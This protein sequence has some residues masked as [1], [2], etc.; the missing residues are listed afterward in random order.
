MSTSYQKV[1]LNQK[2]QIYHV[3]NVINLNYIEQR[4]K[5]KLIIIID[6]ISL[7]HQEY[8]IPLSVTRDH[9]KKFSKDVRNTMSSKL[10]SA[11]TDN[12]V[13][14]T[15]PAHLHKDDISKT[16]RCM[17]GRFFYTH[18]IVMRPVS[19]KIRTEIRWS[20]FLAHI[21]DNLEIICKR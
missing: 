16:K 17:L 20:M 14:T 9:L 7:S 3:L 18:H 21:V 8:R 11:F 5:E 19:M 13:Y 6:L 10:D 4:H 12:R 15:F 2:I 1:S